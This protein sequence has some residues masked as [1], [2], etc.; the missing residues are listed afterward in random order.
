MRT[1]YTVLEEYFT[2]PDQQLDELIRVLIRTPGLSEYFR[3]Y[4]NRQADLDNLCEHTLF[5]AFTAKQPDAQYWVQQAM[6]L[7]YDM[8]V[9]PPDKKPVFN[10]FEPTLMRL[11]QQCEIA[12]LDHEQSRIPALQ[13]PQKPRAFIHWLEELWSTHELAAHPLFPYLEEHASFSEMADY[14]LQESTIDTRLDDLLALGQVGMT[15]RVKLEIGENYW[16]ELGYGDPTQIHTTLFNALLDALGVQSQNVP[17]TLLSESLACGNLL[18]LTALHRQY[19]YVQHGVLAT[20]EVM[21]PERFRRIACGGRRLGLP[22]PALYYL[23]LHSTLDVQHGNGWR[24]NVLLPT[25]EANA[26]TREDI[27]RGVFLRLNTSKDYCDALYTRYRHGL[28]G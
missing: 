25:I 11:L 6:A 12:W 1:E 20:M 5:E 28:L 19:A 2:Q 24:D 16:S 23:D 22:E 15:D 21:A 27:A 17:L 9:S 10:Q 14:F 8:H 18:L 13:F 3:K 4:P 7:L 26:T